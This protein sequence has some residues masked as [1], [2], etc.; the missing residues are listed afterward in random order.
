M[1]WYNRCDGFSS[2]QLWTNSHIAKFRIRVSF[3]GA[4][5]GTCRSCVMIFRRRFRASL[6]PVWYSRCDGSW[7][8]Q[9]WTNSHIAKF[10]IRVPFLGAVAGTCRNG[11]RIFRRLFQASLRS[12][13]YGRCNGLWPMQRWTHS[14]IAKF[15]IRM[16]FLGAVAG[17]CRSDFRIFE[18]RFRASL[19]SV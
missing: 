18:R 6:R 17:T 2:V 7:P 15:P 14:H 19:R 10:G 16:P 13:L 8:V 5:A 11:F 4:V 1:V 9:L 12:V 3:L